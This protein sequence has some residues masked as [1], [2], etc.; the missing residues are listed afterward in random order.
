MHLLD[1]RSALWELNEIRPWLLWITNRSDTYIK[2]WFDLTASKRQVKCL[3]EFFLLYVYLFCVTIFVHFAVVYGIIFWS[4]CRKKL[5]FFSSLNTLT[6]VDNCRMRWPR[7][8]EENKNV[9]KSSQWHVRWASSN[10]W[11]V[12]C[13]V[14]SRKDEKKHEVSVILRP[15]PLMSS[16]RRIKV[17]R[18]S[19]T[20]NLHATR[21][22]CLRRRVWI[23][24]EFRT[25]DCLDRRKVQPST[26]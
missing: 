7:E 20:Q 1:T 9:S 4:F 24:F 13:F 17:I 6:Y 16:R 26:F 25:R 10:V 18:S 11:S 5:P 19:N 22:P 8:D 3:N 2:I 12:R 21:S 23:A 14:E 15:N